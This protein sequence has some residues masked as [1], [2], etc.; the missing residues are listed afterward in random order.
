MVMKL[1]KLHEKQFQ[2]MPIKMKFLSNFIKIV[3]LLLILQTNIC[4]GSDHLQK[5]FV[6]C[7]FLC[8]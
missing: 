5:C 3:V 1:M 6:G 4:R 8:A 2:I 7:F